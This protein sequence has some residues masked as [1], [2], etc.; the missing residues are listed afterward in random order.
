MSVANLFSLEWMV[1]CRKGWLR[2]GLFLELDGLVFG[3]R[4]TFL[5]DECH[6]K[7][8]GLNDSVLFLQVLMIINDKCIDTCHIFVIIIILISY[9]R[10]WTF[11][12]KLPEMM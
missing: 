9:A 6:K 8:S 12:I 11:G 10:E 5:N 3:W 7:V 1:S 2:S 4:C